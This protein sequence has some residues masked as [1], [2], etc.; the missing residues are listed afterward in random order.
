MKY[1]VF[2]IALMAAC[3]LF[4]DDKLQIRTSGGWINKDH[5]FSLDYGSA[6]KGAVYLSRNVTPHTIYKIAWRVARSHPDVPAPVLFVENT[7]KHAVQF[8]GGNRVHYWNSGSETTLKLRFDISGGKP[9]KICLSD[10]SIQ[11][12]EPDELKQN[13]IQNGDWEQGSVADFWQSRDTGII[14]GRVE[15][16]NSPDFFSGSRSLCLKPAAQESGYSIRSAYM[17]IIPGETFVLTF[18][19]KSNIDTTLTGSLDC[20][21]PTNIPDGKHPHKIANFKLTPDWNEYR[22]EYTVPS[23]LSVY[24]ALQ[25]GVARIWF[26][27]SGKGTIYLD[28]LEFYRTTSTSAQ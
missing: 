7:R 21:S 26:S 16:V 2:F 3:A 28:N 17:P 14:P 12:I 13:M 22:L 5:M 20:S 10:I 18:W 24:P 25:D 6:K 1:F 9:G 11:K 19:G 15:L 8:D 27:C 4:S 23:D